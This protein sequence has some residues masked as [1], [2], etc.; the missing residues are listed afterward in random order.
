MTRAQCKVYAI[1][2]L[3]GEVI[4]IFKEKIVNLTIDAYVRQIR[5]LR[6]KRRR[7]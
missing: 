2:I 7:K 4:P 6:T 3:K 5:H 1:R